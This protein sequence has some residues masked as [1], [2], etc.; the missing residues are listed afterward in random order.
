MAVDTLPCSATTLENTNNE[1]PDNGLNLSFAQR[2][3]QKY[4]IESPPAF[5]LPH[6]PPD[7]KASSCGS[8]D[9]DGAGQNQSEEPRTAA[10]ASKGEPEG[11]PGYFNTSNSKSQ[12]D[13]TVFSCLKGLPTEIDIY[14]LL[15]NV[16]YTATQNTDSK[17]R[18]YPYRVAV[19]L[20]QQVPGDSTAFTFKP[21]REAITALHNHDIATCHKKCMVFKRKG[22]NQFYISP[23]TTRFTD[24]KYRRKQ[25]DKL[26][27]IF[28]TTVNQFHTAVFFTLTAKPD[29]SL[30]LYDL[31]KR[32]S[33]AA[34]K[35]LNKY[36]KRAER[37]GIKTA[38]VMVPEYQGNGRI[39]FHIVIFGISRLDHWSTFIEYLKSVG[40]GRS[41]DLAKLTS[42]NGFWHKEKESKP[43][44]GYLTKY[45]KKSFVDP[46]SS[47]MYWAHNRK[48]YSNSECFNTQEDCSILKTLFTDY[49]YL[50]T[51]QKSTVRTVFEPF[52]PPSKQTLEGWSIKIPDFRDY[53]PPLEI[54]LTAYDEL[55]H[56]IFP[57]A[58]Y[59]EPKRFHLTEDS[60]I[61]Y[62]GKCYYKVP[63]PAMA[64][65]YQA[66]ENDPEI[67]AFLGVTA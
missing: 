63:L 50:G 25:L 54:H 10:M 42:K 17:A 47:C 15:Q 45:L 33:S 27:N 59:W 31:N 26:E 32:A 23:Y 1:L 13:D 48:F 6:Y 39:H 8:M 19:E 18:S 16:E 40:L 5:S 36:L 22:F 65:L 61:Y 3:N 49:V 37:D 43:V 67:A 20:L 62:D 60:I 34:L 4:G 9:S 46:A 51:Y 41:N 7:C 28:A 44:S 55:L 29:S 12:T 58:K 66:I 14:D 24:K 2:L 52:F 11:L 21:Y 56:E 35:V 53:I 57:E 64:A 38:Y 30:S